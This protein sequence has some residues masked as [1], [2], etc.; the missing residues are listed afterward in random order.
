MKKTVN[1]TAAIAAVER[2]EAASLTVR[3]LASAFDAHY[4]TKA[5]T[6]HLT[7]W[8]TAIG[9]TDAWAITTDQLNRGVKALLAAGYSPGYTNRQI[10][11]LGSAYKWAK[12]EHLTPRNFRSPTLGVRRKAEDL[13][14]VECN[15]TELKRLR[16]G[17]FAH[18]DRRFALFIALMMDTGARPSEV[19]SRRWDEID[20]DKGE[21]LA[22]TTKTGKPRVLFF[23]SQT[24][25]L[26]RRL[27][28]QDR[29]QLVFGGRTG[30]PNKFRKAWR[31]LT[32]AI[33]RPDLR[34]YDL[35]H[36]AAARL[37]RTGVTLGVASQVLGHSSLILH[38]RYAHLETQPL[39][40]AQESAWTNG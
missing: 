9:D 32:T 22:P 19:L 28:P 6:P 4:P 1:L 40:A 5:I 37:L 38:R 27:R 10:S 33:G 12:D 14:R 16:E 35:R 31:N 17:A 2:F 11:A 24:A 8:L 25:G 34:V 23:T 29:T 18:R 20:L 36:V 13:R 21:I 26:A 15:A 3:E 30:S 39:R 7:G